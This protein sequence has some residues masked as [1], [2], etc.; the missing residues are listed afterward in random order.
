MPK[1]SPGRLLLPFSYIGQ[2]SY[3]IYV[4]HLWI[5]DEL[6]YHRFLLD[7]WRG[8]AIYFVTTIA[9]GILFSKMIEFPVLRLR[10]KIFPPLS[11]SHSAGGAATASFSL[12]PT[13]ALQYSSSL[14]AADQ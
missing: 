1:V 10:D 2:H 14:E 8:V 5:L 13:P 3:P 9:A 6:Q 12:A 4:F 11:I 7:G